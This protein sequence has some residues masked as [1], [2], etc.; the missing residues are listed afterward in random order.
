MVLAALA[1]LA[2]V[3]GR[4]GLRSRVVAGVAL[5]ALVLLLYGESRQPDITARY[6]PGL[7][8]GL[9][10]LILALLL[11]RPLVRR[12]YAAGGVALTAREEQILC[13]IFLFG[14]AAHLAGVVFP[15]F[16]AHDMTFQVHRVED[17]LRGNFLLAVVSS[18]WGYRRTPYPPALYILLAPFA[19][20]SRGLAR[21]DALPLRL[22]PPIIDA[23]SVFLIFYLLRRCKLPDPA[24]LLAAFCYTLVPATYQLLWWGFFPNLFGQ[25]ATLAV[26]TLAIAHYAD[27][28]RPKFFA[29]LVALLALALL[30]HPGTF[31]LTIALIPIL[32]LALALT[33]GRENGRRGAVALVA[34]LAFAGALV[35]LLYYRHF[36]DLV[37][38]QVRD[39]LAGTTDATTADD[40]GW[41]DDYIR[42]RVFAF[43]FVLYFAAAWVAGIRL[44][45]ARGLARALGWLLIAILVTASIFGA[46]HV[47]TG[48][49]VRYFVFVS[50]ALAIGAGLALA[51][52]TTRGRWGQALAGLALAYGT[53]AS[54]IFWLSVTIGGQRSPYP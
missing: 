31:V 13:G 7:L 5:G 3:L 1:G 49:W 9:I 46:V 19:A 18:E 50:P 24:P 17:I 36:T 54:L 15:N 28:A 16:Q 10:A 26:V 2:G 29:A 51:W 12:L 14:A 47:A 34:A 35:Y 43:P 48:V 38:G 45:F 30:S 6:L 52:A 42:L 33:T 41:E 40:R 44:A 32:A 20:L 37:A 11:L 53:C 23:T 39:W 27:L 21:D 22:I 25:W 8:L 4:L